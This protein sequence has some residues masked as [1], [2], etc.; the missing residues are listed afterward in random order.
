MGKYSYAGETGDIESDFGVYVDFETGDISGAIGG[1][2]PFSMGT[3]ELLAIHFLTN[4]DAT[5]I[6]QDGS[7]TLGDSSNFT[8]VGFDRATTPTTTLAG[9]ISN[10]ASHIAGTLS[11]GGFCITT[12]C[13]SPD[14]STLYGVF[15]AGADTD[16]TDTD[17]TD[18]DTTDTDTTDTD[19][20]PGTGTDTDPLSM[21]NILGFNYTLGSET[22]SILTAFNQDAPA[23]VQRTVSALKTVTATYRNSN[24]FKGLFLRG[25]YTKEFTS[26]VNFEVKFHEDATSTASIQVGYA[27]SGIVLDRNIGLLE[28]TGITLNQGAFDQSAAFTITDS[29]MTV[30]TGNIKGNLV[31]DEVDDPF[32]A[33][34]AGEVKLT[35]TDNTDEFTLNGV[36]AAGFGGQV[37][38]DVSGG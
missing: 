16:T 7:F 18:T 27:E 13:D 3:D 22:A 17:T 14:D 10:D 34:A 33:K 26:D 36:F 28:A 32:K 9:A 12:T 24:G 8:F 38:E 35:G 20:D 37:E 25:D 30:T 5:E 29:N 31:G 21:G 19:T 1:S 2:T 11:M 4:S 15:A 23:F 6:A